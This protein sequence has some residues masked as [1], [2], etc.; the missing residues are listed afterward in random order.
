[1]PTVVV[2][3]LGVLD[4]RDAAGSRPARGVGGLPRRR[5]AAPGRLRGGLRRRRPTTGD[6]LGRPGRRRG[7]L[8]PRDEAVRDRRGRR[9]HTADA[10][11]ARPRIAGSPTSASTAGGDEDVGLT[12]SSRNGP[13]ATAL[14]VLDGYA[15]ESMRRR[16]RAERMLAALEPLA[17]KRQRGADGATWQFVPSSRRRSACA[18]RPSR[19]AAPKH[20]G[21]DLLLRATPR[22]PAF[23]SAPVAGS[24]RCTED[25]GVARL[26]ASDGERLSVE[27]HRRNRG[28]PRGRS[29]V[30]HGLDPLTDYAPGAP[31]YRANVRGGVSAA[32]SEAAGSGIDA[33]AGRPA[34]AVAHSRVSQVSVASPTCTHTI[35]AGTSSAY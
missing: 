4:V 32:S 30:R 28:L 11:L 15:R 17:I 26:L 6:M 23:A 22:D 21:A 12:R 3:V 5:R 31:E 16:E 2:A 20:R 29:P 25:L 18:R 8:V 13:A 33:G 34:A 27:R 9:D 35:S 24:L 14:A 19:A 7:V 10:E 1:M